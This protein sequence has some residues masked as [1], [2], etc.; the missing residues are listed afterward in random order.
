[1]SERIVAVGHKK[2]PKIIILLAS[3]VLLIDQ[4]NAL[5]T[6]QLSSCDAAHPHEKWTVFSGLSKPD[7]ASPQMLS[8]LRADLLRNTIYRLCA[9]DVV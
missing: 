9:V 3:P 8:P 1:V 5:I 6:S 2:L 4:N 7:P